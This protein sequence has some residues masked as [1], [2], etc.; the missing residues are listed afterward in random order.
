[1]SALRKFKA[2]S[3]GGGLLEVEAL[4]LP[5][6]EELEIVVL[7][8]DEGEHLG[9]LASA[10]SQSAFSAVWDDPEEDAAWKDL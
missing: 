4:N 8:E 7:E 10:L 2:K 1:M 3:R 6:G 5:A 9:L